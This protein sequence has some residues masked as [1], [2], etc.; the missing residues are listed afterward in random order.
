MSQF[1]DAPLIDFMTSAA[2]SQTNLPPS[3]VP[4]SEEMAT[5]ITIS[6]TPMMATALDFVSRDL[7]PQQFQS[8]RC[9]EKGCVFNAE[10]GTLGLCFEH[11]RRIQEP[12]SFQGTQPTRMALEMAIFGPLAYDQHAGRRIYKEVEEEDYI[13][14][15]A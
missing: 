5:G 2:K 6:P 9:R 10:P 3:V 14:G 11:T 1:S 13:P 12:Q 15:G 4:E 8:P 7:P